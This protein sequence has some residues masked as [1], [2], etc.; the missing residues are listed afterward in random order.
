[1][2]SEAY[3]SLC[4]WENLLNAQ[5][6]AARGKRRY[7]TVAQF[8][9]QLADR[10]LKLQFSLLNRQYQPGPYHHFYIHEP[11][12]RKISA[13]PFRDRIVHHALCNV[14]EPRFERLF[15]PDSYANRK[16]KGTHRAID[17]LQQFARRYHYVLRA[18]IVKHFPSIDH[19]ILSTT[20][21]KVIPEDDVMALVQL[22]IASGDGVLDKEYESVWFPGDDLLALCRPRGLP[23]G[24][25]TSQFWSNCYLH[26]FDQFVKRELRCRAYLRYVDDFA[27]FSDS[28]RQL[29]A[30]KRA[31]IERL[32][33]LRLVIHESKAQVLPVDCGIPWLGFVVYPTHR[34]VKARQVRK[35]V[36][37]LEDRLDASQA[38]QINFAHL[39]ASIQGWINHVRY[40]D[41]WGLRKHVLKRL[42]RAQG[43][44]Q[45]PGECC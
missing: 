13:A 31:L 3:A 7:D 22:I 29:W 24:N 38:G 33:N 2:S 8:E 26:P 27:L 12:R 4:R 32:A 17:R 14:I 25:L 15:I 1:V 10:L 35:A 19:Q 21:A 30:W 23:I 37:R 9:H 6:Q 5:R 39:D 20:L 28:K 34:R 41:T 45:K 16:N 42:H 43:K 18:D 40:A 11:K 44:P 36:R